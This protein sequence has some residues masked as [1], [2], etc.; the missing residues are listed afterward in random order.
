MYY[1]CKSYSV[2]WDCGWGVRGWVSG[3]VCGRA[4]AV[5]AFMVVVVPVGAF[6]THHPAPPTG[7]GTLPTPYRYVNHLYCTCNYEVGKAHDCHVWADGWSGEA[8]GGW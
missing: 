4:V 7:I 6:A 5:V 3:W 8:V 2:W 1:Y